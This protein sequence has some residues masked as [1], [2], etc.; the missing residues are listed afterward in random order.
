MPVR[1]VGPTMAEA[2]VSSDGYG[3]LPTRK[4]VG[5]WLG[6]LGPLVAGAAVV[7]EVGLP[8]GLTPDGLL[9]GGITWLMAV[10]WVTETLDLAATALIPLV[11]FPLTGVTDIKTLAGAYS[12]RFILLLMGGFFI[13]TSVERWNLHRRLALTALS[14]L[15]TGPRQIIFGFMLVTA[16]M[17]MWISNTASILMMLP[18]ATAVLARVADQLGTD[19]ERRRF[20]MALLLGIAYAGS[21]GGLGTP[22]G[23]P[24]NAILLGQYKDLYPNAAP[25]GFLPWMV[26]A[27]PIALALLAF[28]A[29]YLTA[30][31]ARPPRT[32][33]T[34]GEALSLERAAL[35]SMSRPERRVAIVFGLTALLWIFRRTVE[36]G[37]SGFAIPGWANLLG[38]QD[39]VDDSTVA[40]AAALALFILPAGSRDP[41]ERLLD[42]ETAVGIPWGLL[43]LFGGGIAVATAFKATG[44]SAFIGNQA[45]V[46]SGLHPLV[47]TLSLALIV[48][49]LTEITSNTA[50][51]IILMPILAATAD[52]TGVPPLALMLPAALSASCAFMLPVATAPNAIVFSTGKIGISDMART[53]FVINLVGAVIISLIVYAY[54]AD[55]LSG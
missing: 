6:L 39:A 30:V 5:F 50:T 1:P 51:T 24:P 19:Q 35:G 28:I 49:F 17:S 16:A 54:G 34:S 22:I 45:E 36:F 7:A 9:V 41:K 8:P 14:R 31:V 18:I 29:W 4:R 2:P 53:G 26:V 43:V 11:A 48:T 12:D 21:V 52:S 44:L 46:L 38:V 42:W 32:S 10:W 55:L 13:A 27:L 25:I 47:T 37:D 20:E 33:A 15:G 23:T 40:M 3:P